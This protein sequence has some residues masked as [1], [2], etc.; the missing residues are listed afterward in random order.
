MYAKLNCMDGV[1]RF[2]KFLQ[3]Q[4]FIVVIQV[5]FA[6]TFVANLKR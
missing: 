4:F 6:T 5:T 3:T 2:L 1:K